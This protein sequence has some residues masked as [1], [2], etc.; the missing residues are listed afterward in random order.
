[1]VVIAEETLF[2]DDAAFLCSKT[3]AMVLHGQ[4]GSAIVVVPQYQCRV[5]TSSVDAVTGAGFGW[6][7]FDLISSGEQLPHITPYGGE[8][9]FWLGPEGGQYSIFFR[10][11][12]P[13]DLNHWQTPRLIDTDPFVLV[14]SGE[15][16]V[17]CSAE[18]E[19]TNYSGFT[20]PIQITRRIEL[21]Q[22]ATVESLLSVPISPNVR[23]VCYRSV[24]S[25]MNAGEVDWTEQSGA[26][27]IW[28]LGMFKHSPS[29]TV[30]LPYVDSSD[31]SHLPIVNDEYFGKVPS[32]RLQ[33]EAGHVYFRADGEFRSKIGLP[34]MRS[35]D[36][37][38]SYD[39]NRNLLTVV[40]FDFPQPPN[41]YVNSM[42]QMQSDPFDGD[43]VNS[44]NDGPPGP[45]AR[46]LGPF[47]EL[48]NS[49]PAAFLSP[50][51]SML[52]SSCTMH[53][54]GD[55]DELAPIAHNVLSCDLAGVESVFG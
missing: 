48:E 23:S 18:G 10:Q 17:E 43:V 5:M 8:E 29:T 33:I 11:G 1:M 14:R 25:L 15:N 38:G 4:D 13:F 50:G 40:K 21:L 51:K 37:I 49:S 27:S 53:F 6:I 24:N 32:N 39:P 36:I 46:C 19:L 26:L 28:L 31:L 54:V 2:Q 47:Y 44:Y 7:N 52:H 55:R 35:K 45:G 12:T 16:F 34:A 41:K 30:I 42:W 20:F 22:R 9:R 3:D